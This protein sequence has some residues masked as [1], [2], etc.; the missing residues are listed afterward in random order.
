MSSKSL[1]DSSSIEQFS[2]SVYGLKK[3]CISNGSSHH[4]IDGA[5]EKILKRLQ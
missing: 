1:L 2:L 3:I 4:Y 5:L